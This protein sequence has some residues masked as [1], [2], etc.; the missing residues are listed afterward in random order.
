MAPLGQTI[1]S[2]PL[3]T[4]QHELVREQQLVHGKDATS[5]ISLLQDVNRLQAAVKHLH[6][7]L[8]VLLLV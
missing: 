1:W 6:L 7:L 2:S 8:Q 4:L 5:A 3:L